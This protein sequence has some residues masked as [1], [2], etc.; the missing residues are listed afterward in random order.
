VAVFGNEVGWIG[1]KNSKNFFQNQPQH[2][3]LLYLINKTKIPL[4]IATK[5]NFHFFIQ[6]ILTFFFFLTSIK[7]ATILA[8]LLKSIHLPNIAVVFKTV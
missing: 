7:F 5:Q 4:K 2:F 1:L 6:S 3:Y 8:H